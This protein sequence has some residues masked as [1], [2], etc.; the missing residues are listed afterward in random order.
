[1]Q[2]LYLTQ[3]SYFVNLNQHC[4]LKHRKSK[5][6]KSPSTPPIPLPPT[7]PNPSQQIP[8][9]FTPSFRPQ[10]RI[11]NRRSQISIKKTNTPPTYKTQIPPTYF[12]RKH[13][14]S[15]RHSDRS[16]GISIKMTNTHPTYKPQSL[17]PD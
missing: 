4:L 9:L 6:L 7:N 10:R 8:P 2:R 15:R 17:H 12:K 5:K 16:G 3:C 13:P 11:E 14:S 1:M